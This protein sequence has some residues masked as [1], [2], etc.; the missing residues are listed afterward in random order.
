MEDIVKYE[1]K[2]ASTCDGCE[3]RKKGGECIV[4]KSKPND[5]WAYTK[6]KQ[7]QAKVNQAV[8]EYRRVKMNE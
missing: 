6:D 3:R 7:W 5:C 8:A 4:F 2:K 1:Y